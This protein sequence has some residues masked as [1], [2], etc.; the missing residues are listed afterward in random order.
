[1]KVD[2]RNIMSRGNNKQLSNLNCQ[3]LRAEFKHS[4]L[5]SSTLLKIQIFFQSHIVLNGV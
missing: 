1:M 2:S 4:L 3:I 5:T